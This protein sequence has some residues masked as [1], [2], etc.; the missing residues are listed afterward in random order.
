MVMQKSFN[1]RAISHVLLAAT[2]AVAGMSMAFTPTPS[3]SPV[4]Q[5]TVQTVVPSKGDRLLFNQPKRKGLF[6]VVN[7]GPKGIRFQ[8]VSADCT[9]LLAGK[10]CTMT[11]EAFTA[12]LHDSTI[13]PPPVM[14]A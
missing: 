6:E 10:S 12:A 9:R 2:A 13:F 11:V 8:Q 14:D 7:V 5:N 3:P 4:S 1:R